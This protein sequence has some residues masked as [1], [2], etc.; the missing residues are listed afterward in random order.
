[1]GIAGAVLTV[2]FVVVGYF[3]LI[4]EARRGFDLSGDIVRR[5]PGPEGSNPAFIALLWNVL[6]FGILAGVGLCYRHR[7]A[8][9]KRLMLLAML[10]GLTNTPVAHVVGH[11]PSLQSRAGIIVPVSTALFLSLS[12]IHDRV[13]HGRIH[14]VSLWGA[15]LV[16]ASGS[17]FFVVIRESAVWREFAAWLIQ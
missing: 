12:A 11:W 1:V 4:E 17:V 3:T 16:F 9:H 8:V 7:P 13:S 15:I 2:M 14:P 5:P 6:T 10:G